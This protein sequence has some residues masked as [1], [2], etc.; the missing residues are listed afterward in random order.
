MNTL[1]QRKYP[2]PLFFTNA[3]S[4]QAYSN[5]QNDDAKATSIISASLNGVFTVQ[6]VVSN[7]EFQINPREGYSYP[8]RRVVSDGTMTFEDAHPRAVANDFA[9]AMTA[10]S[11]RSD[12]AYNGPITYAIDD[13]SISDLTAT[14]QV[15]GSAPTVG[16]TVMLSGFPEES[17]AEFDDVKIGVTEADGEAILAV[18]HGTE[19]SIHLS[20]ALT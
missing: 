6:A 10:A 1:W 3:S 15:S 11:L 8:S 4:N 14:V 5:S 7:T 19:K 9:D 2:P 20:E 18:S 13:V 16:D 12:G 17:S